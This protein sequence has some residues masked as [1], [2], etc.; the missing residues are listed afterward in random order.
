MYHPTRGGV[1]GGR[2]QFSWEDVKADKH[3]ENYLGHSIKAPVGRWQKG[4]DLHWYTRDKNSR[5]SEMEAAKEEIKR[6]KE[7]EEQAMREALGLAPKRAS[8]PQGNRLD[9]HEFSELV[10]RGSTAEDLGAGHAEAAQV[11]G[12]GFARAP[13][14]WEETSSLQPT[15][16]DVPPE[17]EKEAVPDLSPS[18]RQ[19]EESEDESS[20]K[21]RRREEKKKEKH[22][23][24]EKRR[25]RDSEDKRKPRKDKEKRRHD[26]DSD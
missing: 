2:D 3:R 6:I 18:N 11:Q 7:Q 24:R 13:R 20:R 14:A 16:N 5:D 4:K 21:K 12:L 25:S 9:K 19:E 10:K 15:P 23:R 1:R 17:A 8:R 22:E 26:S